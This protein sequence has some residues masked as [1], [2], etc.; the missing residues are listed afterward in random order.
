MVSIIFI[1]VDDLNLVDAIIVHR[2][3]RKIHAS[4]IAFKTWCNLAVIATDQ[5]SE[6]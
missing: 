6:R 1:V 3:R 5:C 2:A 4:D